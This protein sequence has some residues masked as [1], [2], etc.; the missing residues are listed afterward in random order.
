MEDSEEEKQNCVVSVHTDVV[1]YSF[2]TIHCHFQMQIWEFLKCEEILVYLTSA[3]SQPASS[4]K[5]TQG[6]RGE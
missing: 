5:H 6:E 2:I 3:I 1:T 4:T